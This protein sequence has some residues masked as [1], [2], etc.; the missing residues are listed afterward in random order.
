M[1]EINKND[2]QKSEVKNRLHRRNRH[3]TKYN[4]PKLIQQTPDLAKYVGVNKY[5]KETINFFNPE[6]VKIL[7]QSLLKFDPGPLTSGL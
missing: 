7:N 3:K 1:S 6:A 5:G 2:T 4:F